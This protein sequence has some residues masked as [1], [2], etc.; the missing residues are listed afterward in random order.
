MPSVIG[1][2][3]FTAFSARNFAIEVELGSVVDAF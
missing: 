3:A 2:S 1:V